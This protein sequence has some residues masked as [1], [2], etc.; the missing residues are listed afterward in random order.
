ML[1]G[2]CYTYVYYRSTDRLPPLAKPIVVSYQAVLISVLRLH[3][4]RLVIGSCRLLQ[5][6]LVLSIFRHLESGNSR[7]QLPYS[8]WLQMSGCC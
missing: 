6:P 4:V 2:A 3:L 8:E 5:S 1:R 7:L